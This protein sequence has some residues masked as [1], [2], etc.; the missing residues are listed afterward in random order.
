M[1]A[2]AKQGRFASRTSRRAK[3][4]KPLEPKLVG[5]PPRRPRQGGTGK[6]LIPRPLEVDALIRTVPGGRLVTSFVIVWL[7]STARRSHVR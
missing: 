6:M 5:V 4:E 3:L 2:Q 1:R 7:R